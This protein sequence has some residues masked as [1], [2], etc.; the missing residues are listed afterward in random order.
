MVKNELIKRSPLRVFDKTLHGGVGK[1]NIGVIT[2]KEGVGKTACL[3]HIAVDKL[4]QGKHI[5][6]VSFARRPDNILNW[7]EDIFSEISKKREL[8]DAED[9]H[10]EL[11]KNRVVMSFPQEGM[12]ITSALDSIA[13]MVTAGHVTADAL[14]FDSLDVSL[15]KADD[16]KAIHQFAKS[17]DSE[18]WVSVSLTGDDPLWDDDGIPEIVKPYLDQI[19]VLIDIRHEGDYIHLELAKSEGK[20]GLRDMNLRLDPKTLLIAEG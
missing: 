2:S 9:V 15:L 5:V 12:P 8:E 14:I 20:T 3:V 16:L 1:G 6:H 13:G 4:L 10:N 17:V 11:V 18:V 19:D 7:Y